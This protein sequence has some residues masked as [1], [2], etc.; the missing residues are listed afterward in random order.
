[1]W[2]D[3]NYCWIVL[4]K[5]HWFHMRQSFLFRHR[6][7]LAETDAF[8]SLPPLPKHFTVRCDECRK[9]HIYK[10]KDVLRSEFERPESFRSHPLFQEEPFKPEA[11][12]DST[13]STDEEP[14]QEES[15]QEVRFGEGPLRAE[16]S[17]EEPQKEPTQ[18]EQLQGEARQKEQSQKEPSH[19]EAR[20][21]GTPQEEPPR[22]EPPQEGQ[23][24]AKGA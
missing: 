15:P 18:A 7:P 5:N 11:L 3:A 14:R 4:C 21:E 6:I 8:A 16:A 19:A 24:R 12:D 13:R 22:K 1:M 9:T 2:E 20:K 17:Q 23:T 10:P